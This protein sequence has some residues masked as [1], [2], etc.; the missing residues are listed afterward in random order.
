MDLVGRFYSFGFWVMSMHKFALR[1]FEL[2]S[3]LLLDAKFYNNF[4][5][6]LSVKDSKVNKTM[7]KSRK[8]K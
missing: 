7:H 4:I 3:L 1:P 2:S 5:T 6:K 8:L